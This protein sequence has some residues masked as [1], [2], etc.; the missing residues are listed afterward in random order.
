M[1]NA[2]K[3]NLMNNKKKLALLSLVLA[4]GMVF[5]ACT[6]KANPSSGSNSEPEA[7]SHLVYQPPG[8]SSGSPGW[9]LPAHLP[10]AEGSRRGQR[11]RF[12]V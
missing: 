10:H 1:H 2:R 8:R 6:P 9:P 5:G 3:E 4:A 12:P 11:P 7:S